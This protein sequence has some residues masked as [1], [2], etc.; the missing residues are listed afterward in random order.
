MLV[1][2]ASEACGVY[3]RGTVYLLSDEAV[4]RISSLKGYS[5]S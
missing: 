2:T 5:S 3:L 4:V 1:A